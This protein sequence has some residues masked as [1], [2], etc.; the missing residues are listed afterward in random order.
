[1][2]A[3]IT[4][5]HTLIVKEVSVLYL[6]MLCNAYIETMSEKKNGKLLIDI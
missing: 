5:D 3:Q 4:I 1:M 2:S 6:I